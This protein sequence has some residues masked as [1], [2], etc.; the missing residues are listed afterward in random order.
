[1]YC[2]QTKG[3]DGGDSVMIRYLDCHR[4]LFYTNERIFHLNFDP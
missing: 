1:M 3:R 4:C 2:I